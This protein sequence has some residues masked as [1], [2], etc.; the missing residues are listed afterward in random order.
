M[1]YFFHK[2]ICSVLCLAIL[3]SLSSCYSSR[4]SELISENKEQIRKVIQK[5]MDIF[6]AM[7]PYQDLSKSEYYQQK[8]LEELIEIIERDL[9][10]ADQALFE[11]YQNPND[12]SLLVGYYVT[13]DYGAEFGNTIL[14]C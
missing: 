2:F 4:D 14:W 13:L 6:L 3:I 10:V 9:K 12:R 5:S 1:S 7:P 11:M 8:C